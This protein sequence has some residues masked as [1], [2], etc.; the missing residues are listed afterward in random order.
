M[1]LSREDH[2]DVDEMYRGDDQGSNSYGEQETQER[3]AYEEARIETNKN[4]EGA[5]GSDLSSMDRTDLADIETR[6]SIVT[7]M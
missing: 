4:D 2:E 3:E 1:F 5:E 7:F 6:L